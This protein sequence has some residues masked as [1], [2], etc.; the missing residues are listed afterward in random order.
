[1]A[2]TDRV[3]AGDAG[4]VKSAAQDAQQMLEQ[5]TSELLEF[6]DAGVISEPELE[7]QKTK[8]RWGIP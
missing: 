8:L 2:D 1:M 4:R 6:R 3:G 5:K 7:E